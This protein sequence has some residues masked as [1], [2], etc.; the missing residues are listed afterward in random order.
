MVKL[1]VTLSLLSE[2]FFYVAILQLL[3]KVY[4]VKIPHHEH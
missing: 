2:V 4:S 1:W 3:L